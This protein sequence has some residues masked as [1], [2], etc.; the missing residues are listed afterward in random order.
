VREVLRIVPPVLSMVRL[1]YFM[2]SGAPDAIDQLV[3]TF[4]ANIAID[5]ILQGNFG[6]MTAIINGKYDTVPINTVTREKRIVNIEKFYD[7][8][9]YRPKY[10]NMKN[11]P[12]FLN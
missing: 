6:R 5:E 9:R 11:L 7:T 10:I 8:N 4:F 3:A 12:L 1:G 2:R